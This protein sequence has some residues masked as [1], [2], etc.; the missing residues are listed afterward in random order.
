MSA[1]TIDLPRFDPG[2]QRLFD[3][4]YEVFAEYRKADPVH[5]GIASMRVRWGASR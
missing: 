5:W 2:A 4:P 1:V 3:H